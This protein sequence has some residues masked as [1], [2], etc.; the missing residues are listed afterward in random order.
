M[1]VR[2]IIL[3]AV[4]TECEVVALGAVKVEHALRDGLE[5]LITAI[6]KVVTFLLHLL[7]SVFHGFLLDRLCNLIFE[8]NSFLLLGGALVF[9]IGVFIA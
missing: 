1:H 8:V 7:R 4:D 6:P 2:L 3:V 5:A 9:L